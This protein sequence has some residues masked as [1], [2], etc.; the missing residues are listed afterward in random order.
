MKYVYL[1]FVLPEELRP[2]SVQNRN[3]LFIWLLV[4]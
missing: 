4:H 3:F 2:Y 1:Y